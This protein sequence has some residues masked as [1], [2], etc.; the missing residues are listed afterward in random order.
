MLASMLRA[1]AFRATHVGRAKF[2]CPVCSYRGPFEDVDPPTGLR[3]HA[4]CPRCGSLERHRLQYLVLRRVLDP[5][6]TSRMAM[7][8]FAPEEFFVP[9]LRSR[10]GRYET[11]DVA[12]PGVD[13]H[14]DVQA[15]PF[16]DASYDFVFASHVLEHVEDDLRAVREIRRILRPSGMAILAV[17]LV[18]EVTIEYTAP[19]PHEFGHVRAPGFDYFERFRP[20][21]ARVESYSSEALPERHQLF[22]YENRAGY[23]T[24]ESPLRRPMAGERHP[25]VVPVCYA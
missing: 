9:F 1:L 24:P 17:P 23:P 20:Y 4:Q 8:H 12:M 7:L 3:R 13:H 10:F 25:D 11:A 21:F 6:E 15:L 2:E 5:L 22:V 18:S 14:V 19:N 16:A